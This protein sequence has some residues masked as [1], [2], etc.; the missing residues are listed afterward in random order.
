MNKLAIILL[1][2]P[3]VVG[4]ILLTLLAEKPAKAVE[5]EDANIPQ[6]AEEAPQANLPCK[7]QSCTGNVHLAN[8]ISMFE[9][10]A[11]EVTEQVS[12]EFSNLKR[13]PEGH[14]ILEI[15]EEESDRAIELFGCDCVNSINAL[16]QIRG[17]SMGVEGNTILP[18]PQIKPCNQQ[19][20]EIDS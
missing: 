5:L 20:P 2:S 17:I 8:F 14:L 12:E 9:S 18:G 1:S 15:S 4:S 3:T 16:R 6:K 13:T 19:A 7:S 11:S 10:D